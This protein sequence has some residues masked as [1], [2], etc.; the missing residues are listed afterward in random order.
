MTDPASH[1]DLYPVPDDR[2]ERAHVDAERHRAMSERARRDPEG[3]WAEVGRRID[4][5]RPFTR[6]KDVSFDLDDLHIRWYHDGTLNV[7]ENCVDR[8][9]DTRADQVAILWEG[10]DPE[11]DATASAASPTC[12]SGSAW[13]RA[14]GSRCT[15]R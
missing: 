13:K 14:I 15:C 8:H 11:R 10:D 4:W 9:L 6:V 3:F 12:S 7:C 5:I 2:A 1:R